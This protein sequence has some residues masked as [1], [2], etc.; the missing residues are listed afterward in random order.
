M[1]LKVCQEQP[2]FAQA[3]RVLS[4]ILERRG[5][6]RRART[7]ADY[8]DELEG[9]RT[10][11]IRG[12][13]EDVPSEVQSRQ[14][15]PQSSPAG[16]PA[17]VATIQERLVAPPSMGNAADGPLTLPSLQ[18]QNPPLA[19]PAAGPL[20]S[21]QMLRVRRRGLLV[22]FSLLGMAA[23]AAAVV[24]YAVY[25][26]G[27]QS[28]PSAR[29]EL[30]RALV[31]GSLEGLMR[32]RELARVH[33]QSRRPDADALVRLALVNALLAA[34]YAVD[35]GKD[36]EEALKGVEVGPTPSPERGALA[37]TVRALLA[38]AAGDRVSAKQ[39][40]ELAVAGNGSEVPAFAWL[41]SARVRNLA[42]DAEG[43]AKDLDRALGIGPELLP[44]A[45]DWA[46]SRIDGGDAV[47]AR[48]TLLAML[49]KSPDNSR[50]RLLLADAER[51]LGE[52]GW[53]KRL[54]T[55]CA[56]DSKISRAV[57]AA[58]A[59]ESA[60]QARLDGDRAG[61]LRKARAVAQTTEDPALLGHL[62]LQI[63]RAHV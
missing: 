56:S 34:D 41:A 24:G 44:V 7:L 1:L 61:A 50:A 19:R 36:A 8:A 9:R 12:T 27:K 54:E 11:E 4:E 31:S 38:L 25:G 2:D 45:V 15:R 48:R 37:A 17:A 49:G 33:V 21:T 32:A 23:V 52:A 53:I 59:T 55:A 18:S 30:D 29:E 47:V 5:D 14:D 57:R 42:G 62:S 60:L 10:A 35:A 51:A 3:F 63:G 28:R 43:A 20:S 22:L 39:Q 26:R 46:A 40:A 6:G 16:P 58:C 13:G